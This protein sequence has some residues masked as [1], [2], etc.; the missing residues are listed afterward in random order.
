MSESEKKILFGIHAV[1]PYVRATRKP[2]GKFSVLGA[3]SLNST[4]ESVDLVGGSNKSP[5]A[6]EVTTFN[7][8]L[9]FGLKEFPPDIGRQY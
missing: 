9:T 1:V 4:L 6:T 3:G 2:F 5:W 7:H 8:E